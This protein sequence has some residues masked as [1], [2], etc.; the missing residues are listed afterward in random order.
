MEKIGLIETATFQIFIDENKV[1]RIVCTSPLADEEE[2]KAVVEALNNISGSVM[3]PVLLDYSNV[4]ELDS[5][6]MGFCCSQEAF[7]NISHMAVLIGRAVSRPMAEFFVTLAKSP[8]PPLRLFNDE[9]KALQ[10]L[11]SMVTA[12]KES[13]HYAQARGITIKD[14]RE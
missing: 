9:S 1:I 13:E 7:S 3:H 11:S 4:R 14:I 12:R 8:G 2:D 6:S 10:W 5:G